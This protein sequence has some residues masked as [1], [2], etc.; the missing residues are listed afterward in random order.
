MNK[1]F[2]SLLTGAFVLLGGCASVNNGG[3]NNNNN[4]NGGNTTLI[5]AS[6]SIDL[7]QVPGYDST[8]P[9]NDQYLAVINYLR[10]LNVKCDDPSGL[11]GP[12]GI[13]MQWENH[14]AAAAREHSEDMKKSVWYDHDGSGTAND[15]TGQSFTPSRKSTF[16]ER[17]KYNGYVGSIMAE[18]IATMWSK[19]NPPANNAWVTVMEGWMKSDHG[20]CSNIMNPS[21]TDFGMY[22]SRAAVDANGEYHVYWTQDFG[23]Q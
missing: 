5:D 8:D 16:D 20:H 2:F 4:N 17:I 10:G 11:F 23:G 19:P 14:V 6:F 12:V 15:I 1:L 18:N 3:G 13:D 21:L 7:S 9:I 22:E